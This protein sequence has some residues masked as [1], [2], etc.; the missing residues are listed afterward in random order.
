ML[1]FAAAL[2]RRSWLAPAIPLR[3]TP[4]VAKRFVESLGQLP[5][6][7][8]RTAELAV[9]LLE[10]LYGCKAVFQPSVVFIVGHNPP[11]RVKHALSKKGTVIRQWISLLSSTTDPSTL[12]AARQS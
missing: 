12:Q 3:D 9:L 10:F 7:S 11:S 5:E 8:G 6:R 1:G 2:A 4:F